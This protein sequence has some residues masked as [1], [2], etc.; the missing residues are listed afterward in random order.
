MNGAARTESESWF[1]QYLASNGYQAEVH[2]DLGTGKRPD[3]LVSRGEACFVCELKQF[4]K[5]PFDKAN[6]VGAMDRYKPLRGSV[7]A[8]CVQLGDLRRSGLPLVILLANPNAL[9]IDTS[10]QNVFYALYGDEAIQIRVSPGEGGESP[11]SRGFEED[12][13]LVPG[14]N[15]RIRTLGQY[16]SAVGML[17]RDEDGTYVEIIESLSGTATPLP[18]TVFDGHRDTR[19]VPDFERGEMVRWSSEAPADGST[20]DRSPQRGG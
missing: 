18:R 10:W 6:R 8:A 7:K 9:F 19:W 14:R 16:V 12:V 1:D 4:D 3:Y 13:Q 2:P 17:R 20:V 11:R 5:S 15:G